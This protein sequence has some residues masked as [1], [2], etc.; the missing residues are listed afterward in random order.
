VAQES[1]TLHIPVS[2]RVEK[3]PLNFKLEAFKNDVFLD[4]LIAVGKDKR[5]T[6]NQPH[7][8]KHSELEEDLPTIP[9][10]IPLM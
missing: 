5:T 6:S 1:P 8:Y 4:V 9:Q 10:T 2:R 7:G 3:E